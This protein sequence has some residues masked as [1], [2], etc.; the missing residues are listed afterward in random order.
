MWSR[1]R[2][3][4]PF[5][6]LGWTSTAA[7][8]LALLAAGALLAA[9]A[10]AA[11]APQPLPR[12]PTP[13]DLYVRTPDPAYS[14]PAGRCLR[15]RR[16][17]AHVLEMTSQTWRRPEEVDRTVWKHWVTIYVP[18]TV[19][20]RTALLYMGADAT[21]TRCPLRPIPSS[22]RIAV[23]TDSITVH[24]QQVPNEPLTFSGETKSRREDGSSLTP[25]IDS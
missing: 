17:R 1:S 4:L 10:P 19:R 20:Y 18:K 3:C 16:V 24:L 21:P 6:V 5:L 13:L 22:S 2:N 12:H 23:A 15:R 7:R 9:R 14:L 8:L 25:G 11:P